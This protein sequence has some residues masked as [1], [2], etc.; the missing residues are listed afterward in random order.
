[1]KDY[2]V[3]MTVKNNYLF[4]LMQIKGIDS[5]NELARKSGVGAQ[6]ISKYLALK[7]VPK[8]G[9]PQ[10]KWKPTA[11][12]LAEFFGCMVEDMFPS[13][14]LDEKLNKNKA[15]FE[16]DK[17]DFAT[18]ANSARRGSI[19][20][21]EILMLDAAKEYTKNVIKQRLNTREY[22]IIKHRVGLDGETP[23]TLEQITKIV[24]SVDGHEMVRARIA[25]IE[26]KA[27]RKLK[28]SAYNDSVF[29]DSAEI[30]F[31]QRNE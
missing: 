5:I 8:S 30:I 20:P 18:F 16:I 7:D 23:K 13:Q 4:R 6:T 9:V 29:R 24:L 31:K 27:M 19:A 10:L 17:A 1:M 22:E 3:T 14:H 26:D 25:Q 15:I 2:H 11:I 21:D 12:A 28:Y